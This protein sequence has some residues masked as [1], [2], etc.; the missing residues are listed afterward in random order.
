MPYWLGATYEAT[1]DPGRWRVT[2]GASDKAR[3]QDRFLVPT[4]KVV[5]AKAGERVDVELWPAVGGHL[6]LTAHDTERRRLPAEVRIL[7]AAGTHQPRRWNH[8]GARWQVQNDLRLGRESAST[9]AQALAPGTYT[10]ELTLGHFR[11]ARA[12][13]TIEAGKTAVLEVEMARR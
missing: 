9:T 6:E 12:E 11:D 3:G 7:D 8:V 2:V 13:V 5:D 1:V 10:V 4:S